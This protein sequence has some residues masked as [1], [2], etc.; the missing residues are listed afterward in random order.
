P[1]R[2]RLGGGL[3]EAGL[4][5]LHHVPQLREARSLGVETSLRRGLHDARLVR[6]VCVFGGGHRPRRGGARSVHEGLGLRSVPG[7]LSRGGWILR[8]VERGGGS[9]TRGGAGLER[10]APARGPEI[11]AG[12]VWRLTNLSP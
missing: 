3:N 2:P 7:Y 6:R 11:D 8:I 1:P 10:R 5:L 9:H 4:C 12:R